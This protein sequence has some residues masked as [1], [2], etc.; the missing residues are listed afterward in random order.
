MA[1][2]IQYDSCIK[3]KKRFKV[4]WIFAKIVMWISESYN[5]S[6]AFDDTRFRMQ[7]F[8]V[9]WSQVLLASQL[10]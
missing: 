10:L 2:K 5:E 9:L 4:F 7:I 3:A 1:D 8:Y 6:C